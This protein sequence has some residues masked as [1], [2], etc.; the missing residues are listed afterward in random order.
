MSKNL[1]GGLNFSGGNSKPLE[2]RKTAEVV[3]IP[4]KIIQKSLF[5]WK[6]FNLNQHPILKALFAVPNGL[7]AKNQ[8]VAAEMNR[9]GMTAGIQDVIL[10]SPSAD[11]KYPGLLIEFK[12]LAKSSV[13]SD[14]QKFYHQFFAELGYKTEV[15]RCWEDAADCIIDYLNL[16]IR[17]PFRRN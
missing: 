16:P 11:K 10:L 4:E 5:V 17:K 8:A 2:L 6:S 7:W 9:Q 14:E 12:T 1:K 13:Q 15:F 3:V